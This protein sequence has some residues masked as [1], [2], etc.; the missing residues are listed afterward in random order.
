MAGLVLSL[1]GCTAIPPAQISAAGDK[2]KAVVADID[3]TLTPDVLSIH[4]AR[5]DAARAMTALSAQGYKVIYVTARYPMLQAGLPEWLHANGFPSGELNVAQSINDSLYP[6][7]FKARVLHDYAQKGWQL[8]YA[9]G[10]SSTDFTAYADAGIPREH[11]FALKRRGNRDCQPGSYQQCL[12]NWSD[13]LATGDFALSPPLA[14][15]ASF[16]Q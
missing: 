7:A 1:T 11:V 16:P 2:G 8:E 9:Y 5:T 14:Y 3:G 13:Y 4:T 6:E 15:H 10:D 12:D